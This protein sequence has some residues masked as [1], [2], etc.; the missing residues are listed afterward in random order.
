M[1]SG[2]GRNGALWAARKGALQLPKGSGARPIAP[3]LDKLRGGWTASPS[4]GNRHGQRRLEERGWGITEK[5]VLAT[6]PGNWGQRGGLLARNARP[7][8]TRAPA[9]G[10]AH[11][12]QIP[13]PSP[14]PRRPTTTAE[15]GGLRRTSRL[16]PYHRGWAA[17]GD[18]RAGPTRAHPPPPCHGGR[19]RDLNVNRRPSPGQ[20][21][22]A[23]A[24]LRW[25][26]WW[27]RPAS[28]SVLEGSKPPQAFG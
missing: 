27:K 21:G 18:G 16:G 19:V 15:S 9:A 20:R 1:E 3:D 13:S 10:G 22:G 23:R 17:R 5:W 26:L 2:W 12:A 25:L 8:P 6:Q 14:P 7:R 4:L 24:G 11:G 28:A